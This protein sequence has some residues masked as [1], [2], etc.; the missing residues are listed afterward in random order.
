MGG[1]C[2]TGRTKQPALT[3][4]LIASAPPSGDRCDPNFTCEIAEPQ[5]GTHG[6]ASAKAN[7]MIC[8][9]TGD[10]YLSALC[11]LGK[12]QEANCALFV[13]HPSMSYAFLKICVLRIHS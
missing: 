7:Y 10:A 2:S 1:K 6:T 5:K 4:F 9:G 8:I 11:A 12:E 13:N 3:L